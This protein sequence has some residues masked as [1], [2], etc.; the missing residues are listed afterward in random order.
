M[1]VRDE[2]LLRHA[3]HD[4]ARDLVSVRGR[5]SVDDAQLVAVRDVDDLVSFLTKSASSTPA[6]WLLVVETW[7]A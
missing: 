3:G 6:I 2:E 7:L 4:H 1:V 5:V